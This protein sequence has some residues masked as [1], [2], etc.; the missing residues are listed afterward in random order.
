MEMRRDENLYGS[1]F[2]MTW[3]TQHTMWTLGITAGVSVGFATAALI[4]G[5]P[6]LNMIYSLITLLV[7]VWCLR[8]Y[9]TQR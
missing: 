6:G 5:Q 2:N 3:S 8:L 7:C 9:A 1:K 4:A